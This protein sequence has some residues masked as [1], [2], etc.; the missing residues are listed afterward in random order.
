MYF[1]VVSRIEGS[2]HYASAIATGPARVYYSVGCFAKAPKW[3]A[4]QGYHLTVFD[5]LKNA[6]TFVSSSSGA[7]S[8]FRC[9]CLGKVPLPD[10][11]YVRGVS[12]GALDDSD[13]STHDWPKG[14]GMFRRVKIIDRVSP[15]EIYNAGYE[16]GTLHVLEGAKRD[17]AELSDIISSMIGD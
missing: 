4:D 12:S 1:K 15:L 14:T 5:S 10:A 6:A 13:H 7:S 17:I 3:L 2:S 16:V 8:I 9:E 11:Q